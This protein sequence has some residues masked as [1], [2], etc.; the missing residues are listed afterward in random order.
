MKL[1]FFVHFYTIT[2][3]INFK[4]VSS[5]NIDIFKKNTLRKLWEEAMHYDTSGR[6]GE[7]LDSIGHCEKSDYKYFS[8]VISGDKV[9]FSN[10][11]NTAYA[12]I[13]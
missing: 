4:I 13:K 12:V 2:L 9:E 10:G 3:L 1:T 5:E 7:E 6:K 11:I 8:H